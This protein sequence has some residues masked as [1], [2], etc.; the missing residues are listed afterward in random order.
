VL[1]VDMGLGACPDRH[2]PRDG[3]REGRDTGPAL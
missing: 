3:D 2:A 1:T